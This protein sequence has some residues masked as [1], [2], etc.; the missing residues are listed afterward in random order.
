MKNLKRFFIMLLCVAMT[1]VS[2]TAV[3][4][5]T[6]PKI[7]VTTLEAKPGDT[8][9][10]NIE[11]SDNPGIMSMAF[12]VTYDSNILTYNSYEKGYLTSYTVYDMPEKGHVSFV[13]VENKDVAKNGNMFTLVFTV[14]SDAAVGKSVITLAN[15]NRDKYGTKLHNSFSTSKQENIVPKVVSGGVIVQETCENSGH[16]YG[17]WKVVKQA[18]CT[19]TG[20]KERFCEGCDAREEDIIPIAHSYATDW[21]IDKVATPSEMGIKSK[22]CSMCDHVVD[23]TAFEFGDANGDNVT[24]G[25][26][27]AMI[28]KYINGAN[29]SINC[30]IADVNFDGKINN[31]DYILLVR[32][33]NGWSV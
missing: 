6:T 5:A 25:K 16:K 8:V 27:C 9:K 18:T 21:T 10:I 28:L 20:V 29:V 19:E 7:T 22:H 17:E 14:K 30:D 31:K 4:A 15:I 13:N 12:C 1:L 11:I 24:T 3:S 26:D 23:E 33:L 32:Y 2:I